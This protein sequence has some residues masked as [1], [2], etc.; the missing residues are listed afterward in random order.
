MPKMKTNRGAMKRFRKTAGGYKFRKAFRNHTLTKKS[1]K[2][3]RHARRPGLVG[4][5]DEHAIAR[6][7]LDA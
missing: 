2:M 5:S 4:P 7:F 6:M 1:Q 3:K